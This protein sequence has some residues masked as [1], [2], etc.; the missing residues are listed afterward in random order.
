[1]L[2]AMSAPGPEKVRPS[3]GWF[4]LGG[5][6]LV[7]A[8]VSAIVLFVWTLSSFLA[9][10]VT[11]PADGAPHEVGVPADGD[12]MLWYDEDATATSCEVVDRATGRPIL[13]ETVSGS[14]TRDDGD[15][16]RVGS[17]RFDPG[18]GDLTVTC[19]SPVGTEVEIGPAPSLGSFGLGL[20]LTIAVPLV[21]GGLGL[22]VLLVTG[23]LWSTRATTRR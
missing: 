13:L 5:G 7:A 16:G 20:L 11:V 9:T 2:A 6:L 15:G 17:W 14:L 8:V 12:R 18:S 21:L 22:V 23:I 4:V 10:D 3:W 1:M 19:T